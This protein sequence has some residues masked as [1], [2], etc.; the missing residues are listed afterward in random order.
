MRRTFASAAAGS[1]SHRVKVRI[2]GYHPWDDTLPESDLPWANMMMDPVT[3]SS[4]RS[5]GNT[6]NLVG[7]ETAIRIF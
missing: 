6:L 2:I 7:G 1:A 4:L 3:G 5:N